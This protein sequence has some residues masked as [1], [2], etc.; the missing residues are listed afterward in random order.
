[1]ELGG[2][3]L[4]SFSFKDIYPLC[5]RLCDGA[6]LVNEL[7]APGDGAPAHP[8]LVQHQV[9]FCHCGVHHENDSGRCWCHKHITQQ[10]IVQS[11][12]AP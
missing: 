6:W 7:K 4:L 9:K 1:M 5:G 3:A 2:G 11:W 10:Y 12:C 8:T